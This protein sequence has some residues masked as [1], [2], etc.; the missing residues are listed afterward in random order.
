MSKSLS[1]R[2]WPRARLPNMSASRTPLNS[3]SARPNR[4]VTDSGFSV[5][6]DERYVNA[7][8]DARQTQIIPE[9]YAS[10]G[11]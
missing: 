5:P 8:A 7:K 3:A 6:M 11:P 9:R 4:D 10:P 1:A 2:A